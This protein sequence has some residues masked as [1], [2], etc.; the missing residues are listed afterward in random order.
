M[1]KTLEM[2]LLRKAIIGKSI[3]TPLEMELSQGA[4]NLYIYQNG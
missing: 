2:E 4:I 3:N 1:K